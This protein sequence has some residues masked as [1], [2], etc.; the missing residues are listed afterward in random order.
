MLSLNLSHLTY[1]YDENLPD[2]LDTQIYS[3]WKNSLS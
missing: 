2:M 1:S 3:V